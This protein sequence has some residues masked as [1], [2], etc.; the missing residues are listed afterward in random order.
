MSISTSSFACDPILESFIFSKAKIEKIDLN[1]RALSTEFNNLA[2]TARQGLWAAE[3]IIQIKTIWLDMY[4]EFFMQPP[5]FAQDLNT[6]QNQMNEIASE[7][8]VLYTLAK[9][10]DFEILHE[11]IVH[12]QTMLVELY[13][14]GELGPFERVNL[15]KR[16]CHL[17]NR[18]SDKNLK[19]R[20][21]LLINLQNQWE[22]LHEISSSVP[23]LKEFKQLSL[24]PQ[25]EYEDKESQFFNDLKLLVWNSFSPEK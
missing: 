13:R 25:I 9:Q 6:W 14:S 17:L 8:R 21:R 4:E 3:P 18:T 16:V 12:M 19:D 2:S 11:Q 15:I 24:L 7:I 20:E 23:P 22:L 5:K 1:F 10:K